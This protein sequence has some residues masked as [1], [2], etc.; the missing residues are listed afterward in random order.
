MSWPIS[1]REQA[2]ADRFYGALGR[3]IRVWSEAEFLVGGLFWKMTQLPKEQARALFH[4]GRNWRTKTEM[5]LAALETSPLKPGMRSALAKL[6]DRAGSYAAF[7]NIVAHNMVQLEPMWVAR[8]AAMRTL[9]IRPH[10]A[11]LANEYDEGA[12]RCAQ[13]ETATQNINLLCAIMSHALSR[14]AEDQLAAPERLER[15]VSLLPNEAHRSP[16]DPAAEE[17]ILYGIVRL[18]FPV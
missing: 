12:I 7:R 2:E 11:S 3:C 4:S 8:G 16:S 14:P 18:H 1:A 9:C 15:L 5:F 17:Q 10:D 6:I 13:I